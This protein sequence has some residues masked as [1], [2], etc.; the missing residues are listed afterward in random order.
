M[1]EYFNIILYSLIA[2]LFALLMFLLY[3]IIVF[4]HKFTSSLI[5]DFK[6]LQIFIYS[7]FDL[8]KKKDIDE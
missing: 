5:L 2:I 7:L 8:I 4:L 1:M 3:R 6:I